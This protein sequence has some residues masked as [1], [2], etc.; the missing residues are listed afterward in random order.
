MATSRTDRTALLIGLPILAAAI[1][2][3][4]VFLVLSPRVSSAEAERDEA[5]ARVAALEAEVEALADSLAAVTDDANGTAPLA[6]TDTETEDGRYFAFVRGVETDDGVTLATVD[7]AEFLTGEEA[8]AAAAAAG[9]ESPPPNDYWISNVN[10]RLRTFPVAADGTARLVTSRDGLEMDGYELTFAG[11]VEAYAT[12][13]LL[14]DVPYWLEIERG[15]I[16]AI[17][18]QYLP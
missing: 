1:A 13:P 16:T 14:R 17:E 10:P 3:L 8:A 15:T 2:A 11:W 9:E 18:E 6:E 5:L 4:A 12:T 7:F